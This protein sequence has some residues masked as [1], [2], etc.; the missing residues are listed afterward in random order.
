[1]F[2]NF[3]VM[4]MNRN[5]IWKNPEKVPLDGV[6]RMTKFWGDD[7]WKRVAYAD[8]PQ[9]NFFG[10]EKVKQGNDTIIAAFRER[11][12]KVAGFDFVPD[13][14]PMKNSRNV[15]VYYLFLAS[16]KP[17]AAKIIT[18]IFSKYR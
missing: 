12:K 6:E 9:G 10:P 4:D 17:V 16:Q 8:S 15:E 5:A 13:P 2:L 18:E 14:L 1:M 7:S 3:P 11:L